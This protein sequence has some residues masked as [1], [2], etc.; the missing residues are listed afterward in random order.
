MSRLDR[1]LILR[2]WSLNWPNCS[3]IVLLYN[4]LLCSLCIRRIEAYLSACSNVGM[5]FLGTR[6]SPRINEGVLMFM[7]GGWF[8]FEV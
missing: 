5:I 4:A 2:D 8:C 1:F 3:P 7:V 6:T